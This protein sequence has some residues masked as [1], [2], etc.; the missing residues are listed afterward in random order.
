MIINSYLQLVNP[1]PSKVWRQSVCVN[2]RVNTTT[3]FAIYIYVKGEN[4]QSNA[5][6]ISR[7]LDIQIYNVCEKYK[8]CR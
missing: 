5:F 3:Q 6:I 1:D 8:F 2:N 7:Y 4:T